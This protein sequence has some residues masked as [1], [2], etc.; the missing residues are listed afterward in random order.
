MKKIMIFMAVL[1]CCSA[2][3]NDAKLFSGDYSYKLSGKIGQLSV[4]DLKTEDKDSVL[5]IFN[6]LA[7]SLSTV[8][9]YVVE[10]SIYLMPYTKT[11]TFIS[12]TKTEDY[13]IK[14]TGKGVRYDDVIMLDEV[15]DG[16]ISDQSKNATIHGDHISTVA[17][18]N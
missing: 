6:E 10:D 3:Q 14:I 5:L 2:C 12:G 18:R 7:G 8:H 15:Y 9:A 17:N 16:K 13:E 1:V 4:I 11:M